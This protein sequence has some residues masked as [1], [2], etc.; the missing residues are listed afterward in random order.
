MIVAV[1]KTKKAN[2]SIFYITV[3]S[4]TKSPCK[5]GGACNVT[6]DDS[7]SCQCAEGF[8]G[9]NCEKGTHADTSKGLYRNEK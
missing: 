8:Y 3:N 5:N 9:D 2:R 4:C 7:Y 6:G 1:F